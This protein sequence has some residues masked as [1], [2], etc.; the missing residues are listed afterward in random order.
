MEITSNESAA[1]F[2]IEYDSQTNPSRI[3]LPTTTVIT[4]D[5]LN[6]YNNAYPA[7]TG[8]PALTTDET[9]YIRSTVTDPFGYYDI[10]DLGIEHH[11]T[12]VAVCRTS[13]C[14]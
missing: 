14:R 11:A 8:L 7:G 5:Q 4:I 1:T 10:N 12:R 13:L 3:D 6:V 2:Q 9:V